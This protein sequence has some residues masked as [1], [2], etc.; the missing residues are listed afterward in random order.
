MEVLEGRYVPGQ[1]RNLV[2]SAAAAGFN[3]L[4]VWGGG[5]CESSQQCAVPLCTPQLSPENN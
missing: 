2:A 5:I 1:H 4:R 3:T